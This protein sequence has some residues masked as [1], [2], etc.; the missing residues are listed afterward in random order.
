MLETV[1]VF[2]KGNDLVTVVKRKARGGEAKG[3]SGFTKTKDDNQI[4]RR[5][6]WLDGHN[7]RK[8]RRNQREEW[9]R[10]GVFSDAFETRK[11]RNYFHQV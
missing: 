5:Q 7:S 8:R 6:V 9:L 10:R 1:V 4:S 3:V 11:R 2:L